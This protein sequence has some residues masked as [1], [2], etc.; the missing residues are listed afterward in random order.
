MKN[1]L[2]SVVIPIYNVEKYLRK[3]LD[4]IVSQ[5][6][7]NF[8]VIMVNDGSTDDSATI[9]KEYDIKYEN[10]RLINQ[11]NLGLGGARNTGI[12][13]SH[14]EFIL[15][16]DSDDWLHKDYV[17][18]LVETA[19]ITGADVV[20]CNSTQ[21]WENGDTRNRS[22]NNNESRTIDDGSKEQY[23]ETVSYVV[24]NKIFRRDIIGETRFPEHMSKQDYAWTPI[25]IARAK[26]IVTITDSL[27]YYLWRSDSATNSI[28]INYNL[29]K[30]QNIL[31]ESSELNSKYPNLLSVYFVRNIMGSLIWS[32]LYDKKNYEEIADILDEADI[33]YPNWKKFIKEKHIGRRKT[34]WAKLIAKRYFVIARLYVLFIYRLQVI[35]KIIR[36]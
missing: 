3:C 16:P 24:W 18:K 26:K 30:A 31:S 22:Y 32:M 17:R 35:S 33:K 13:N 8:E 25:I 9:A 21:V 12:A 14:G 6:Y 28:K 2:V 29:L 7:N 5:S 1:E 15:L 19:V 20:E 4:S 11:E 10:F 34:F 23:L 27:Y 36:N